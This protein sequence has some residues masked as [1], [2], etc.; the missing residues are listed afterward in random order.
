MID[1]KY[2]FFIDILF[3]FFFG[4]IFIGFFAD[5]LEFLILYKLTPNYV[6]IGYEIGRIPSNLIGIEDYKKWIVLILLLCQIMSLSFYLEILEYNF[7]SLNKNTGKNIKDR[8]RSQTQI[9][10]DDNDNFSVHELSEGYY[11][12]KDLD[13]KRDSK[14]SRV[15]RVSRESEMIYLSY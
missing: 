11:I 5:I 8:E 9:S 7:C 14:I 3:R 2:Y 13:E 12:S 10:N 4:L 1:Y 6:I 15:S